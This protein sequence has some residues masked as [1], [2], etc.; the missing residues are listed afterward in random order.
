MSPKG[1]S[2]WP[3]R[4]VAK[5]TER[6]RPTDVRDDVE[7]TAGWWLVY[8]VAVEI[9]SGEC[10][11]TLLSK[12]QFPRRLRNERNLNSDLRSGCPSILLHVPSPEDQVGQEHEVV[13]C[14]NKP[15]WLRRQWHLWQLP[16]RG[17]AWPWQWH[18]MTSKAIK[19]R[20]NIEAL[21]MACQ[22][23]LSMVIS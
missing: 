4:T 19:P 12:C 3:D 9:G 14:R 1:P 15:L 18:A 16:E 17:R 10:P 8:F 5:R 2:P 23:G 22:C 7:T 20:K 11:R 21:S 13:S 6:P